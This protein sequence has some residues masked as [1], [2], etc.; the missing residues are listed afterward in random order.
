MGLN[1]GKKIKQLRHEQNI[2]QEQLAEALNISY[3]AVSKWENALVYPD[4][5]LVPVIAEFFGVSCDA[6]L[7]HDGRSVQEEIEAIL[8]EAKNSENQLAI[9]EGALK[10]FPKSYKLMMELSGIY[11]KLN[12]NHDR[13]ITYCRRIYDNCKDLKLKYEAVQLLCYIYRSTENY[14]KIKELAEQMPEIYQTRPALI[15]YSMPGDE[16]YK[17]MEEYLKLLK[18]TANSIENVLKTACLHT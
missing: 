15:F 13:I 6:L 11:S 7:T 1:I 17:G 2:T 14:E 8:E 10:R 12:I 5:T 3:Q 9:L 4:I 18:E 16:I